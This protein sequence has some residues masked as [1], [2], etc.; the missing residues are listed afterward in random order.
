LSEP[1]STTVIPFSGNLRLSDAGAPS[2]Q[3]SPSDRSRLSSA[4][5]RGSLKKLAMLAAITGPMSLT[6]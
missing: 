5:W 2:F 6:S 3:R 4:R 1:V